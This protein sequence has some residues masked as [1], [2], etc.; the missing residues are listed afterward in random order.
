MGNDLRLAADG[1]MQGS[2][3]LRDA[4]KRARRADEDRDRDGLDFA[5]ID[6][7]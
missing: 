2:R 1:G 7:R 3:D 6:C 5:G 4:V